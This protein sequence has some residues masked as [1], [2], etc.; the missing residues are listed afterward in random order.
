MKLFPVFIITTLTLL[1]PADAEAILSLHDCIDTAL[2]NQPTMRAAQAG[3]AAGKGREMQAFAP[4][5]PQ[6]TAS[7]GYSDNRQLGGAFGDSTTKSYTTTLSAN[8]TIYDFGRTGNALDAARFGTQSAQFD[9]DRVKQD[10]ILNTKQAYFALLQAK[11]LVI[12]SQKTL[13]QAE[14][15]LKQAE[16]FFRAG[17]KPRFDVTRAEVEVNSARLNL[18]NANNTVRIRT[19]ALYN[20]MGSEP[21][22]VL[23]IEDVL[24]VSATVPSYELVK[25]A[26]LKN[27]PEMR[28]AEADIEAARSR[29][30][31]AESGYFP[32]LSASGA[33]NWAHGTSS[34]GPLFRGDV[35]DSWN[36]GVTLSLPL[37]EGGL[38]RGKV[39]EARA[40]QLIVEAQR[41]T[42][43]QSVLIELSQAYADMES[44]RVRIDVMESSLQKAR[45]NLSIAQGRYEAGVGPYIEI[46]D[47]QVSAVNAETDHVQALYDYQL[48][49]ARLLKATGAPD[50]IMDSN[51]GNP[52]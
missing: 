37:F 31:S 48:A 4:Y 15:H 36:A 40:N 6:I 39:G 38:T 11:R 7:T 16:A 32:T 45:E 43:R 46:T 47:A 23:D 10:V 42:L 22:G 5:L 30:K 27:R 34:M 20:A 12:V 8:Q 33:Y 9:A 51:T 19:I 24:T 35:Q 1:S 44:A 3:V 14:S 2:K 49:V 52:R 26:A 18:I 17:S 28:K 29:I 21:G 41:D 25:D 13:E 50:Q